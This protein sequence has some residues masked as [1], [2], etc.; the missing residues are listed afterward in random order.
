MT[1]QPTDGDATNEGARFYLVELWGGTTPTRHEGPYTTESQYAE[2]ARQLHREIDEGSILLLASV[3]A[4]G[5]E[6]CSFR[7][8][9]FE[10]AEEDDG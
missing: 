3:T 5:F 8:G 4:T 10:E 7:L 6:L 1:T 2:A 9:F